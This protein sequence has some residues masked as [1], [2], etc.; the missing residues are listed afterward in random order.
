MCE[1]TILQKYR[2][3]EYLLNC[4]FIHKYWKK[5][6]YISLYN[7]N[8]CTPHEFFS[9]IKCPLGLPK[10]LIIFSRHQS[11]STVHI[12]VVVSSNFSSKIFEGQNFLQFKLK[13]IS[14]SLRCRVA[15]IASV[16][17]LTWQ[18]LWSWYASAS[19]RCSRHRAWNSSHP[20]TFFM[21]AMNT[22]LHRISI[23]LVLCMKLVVN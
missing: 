5:I 12:K 21:T 15:V 14:L 13:L 7:S 2:L 1:Q 9:A 6:I 16:H 8:D 22:G 18:G 23:C 20:P 19:T 4:L 3:V 11:R 17:L 10:I